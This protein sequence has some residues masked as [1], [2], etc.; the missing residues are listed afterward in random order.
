LNQSL[1][2]SP[3]KSHIEKL[4]SE[5]YEQLSEYDKLGYLDFDQL[6]NV[7][8]IADNMAVKLALQTTF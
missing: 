3:K 4:E 8:S 7:V 6:E 1:K 5:D 2:G